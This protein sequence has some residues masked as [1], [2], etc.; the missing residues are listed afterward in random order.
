[1]IKESIL[2]VEGM[3]QVILDNP[4]ATLGA[5]LGELERRGVRIHPALK[6][7]FKK[8]YGYTS[9]ADGIRHAMTEASVGDVYEEARFMVPACSAFVNYLLSKASEAGVL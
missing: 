9:D 5:A 2:A 4:S 3:A 7:G 6:E 1:A 8:I